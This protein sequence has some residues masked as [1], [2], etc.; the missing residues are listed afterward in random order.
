MRIKKTVELCA[1]GLHA[2]GQFGL[3]EALFFHEH[4][5]LARDN[6]L[7]RPCGYLLVDSFLLQKVVERRSNAS[8][9]FHAI[10]FFLFIAS[11][12]SASGVFCVFFMNA[13]KSTILPS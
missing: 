2:S 6:A 11:S 10:S 1:A 9:S 12:R 8:F 5:K 7:D 13:C 4:V 3:G